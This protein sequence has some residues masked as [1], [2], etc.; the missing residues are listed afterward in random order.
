MAFTKKPGTA[1]AFDASAFTKALAA[2]TPI[3]AK[4]ATQYIAWKQ[5]VESSNVFDGADKGGLRDVLN[6]DM[7]AVDRLKGD[8]DIHSQAILEMRSDIQELQEAPPAHPF[9]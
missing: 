6:A 2:G 7:L 9:P 4:L 5:W 1:P 3:S 8:V